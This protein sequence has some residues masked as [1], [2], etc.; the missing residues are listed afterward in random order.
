MKSWSDMVCLRLWADWPEVEDNSRPSCTDR[1]V[2]RVGVMIRCTWV[3]KCHP[4]H[5]WKLWPRT[6]LLKL[7]EVSIRSIGFSRYEFHWRVEHCG[8]ARLARDLLVLARAGYVGPW[9]DCGNHR[10]Y[11]AKNYPTPFIG[12][13]GHHSLR[14][15]VDAALEHWR[16]SQREA[17]A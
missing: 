17:A 8:D 15:A 1:L 10:W 4:R 5:W 13:G 6:S 11:W 9:I 16:S 12:R 2:D 7:D 3:T 14:A